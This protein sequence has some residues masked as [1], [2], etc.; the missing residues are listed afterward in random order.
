MFVKLFRSL[1]KVQQKLNE[2]PWSGYVFGVEHK[3]ETKNNYMLICLLSVIF[4]KI[5]LRLFE[6]AIYINMLFCSHPGALAVHSA[7]LVRV[8]TR[9]FTFYSG[10]FFDGK[11]A[12]RFHDKHLLCHFACTLTT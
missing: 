9:R 3:R 10:E 12:L 8:L 5:F 7:W 2:L 4:S 1:T 11:R 6:H